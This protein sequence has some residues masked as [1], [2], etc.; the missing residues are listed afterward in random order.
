MSLNI[1]KCLVRKRGAQRADGHLKHCCAN[2]SLFCFSVSFIK[3]LSLNKNS[4][5]LHKIWKAAQFVDEEGIS[6]FSENPIAW[7]FETF[8]FDWLA[9]AACTAALIYPREKC[10]APLKNLTGMDSPKSVQ[11]ALQTADR[12][13]LQALTGLPPPEFPFELAAEFHYPTPDLQAK[14]RGRTLTQPYAS[15]DE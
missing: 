6:H 7:K 5:P 1:Q 14:W 3:Q 11:A 15:K 10:F 8:I 13:A 12:M 4:I 2:L 9:H